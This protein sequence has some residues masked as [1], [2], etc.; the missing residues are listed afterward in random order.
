MGWMV[1]KHNVN[2]LICLAK[3]WTATTRHVVQCSMHVMY[4][5]G[6]PGGCCRGYAESSNQHH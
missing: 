3:D 6:H 5:K 4:A 2:S 1:A